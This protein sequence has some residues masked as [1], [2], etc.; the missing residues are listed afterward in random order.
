M[1]DNRHQ[2]P[3][4]EAFKRFAELAQEY[5]LFLS[6]LL[7]STNADLDHIGPIFSLKLGRTP[8]IGMTSFVICFCIPLTGNKF[9]TVLEWLGISWRK[10]EK[11][12]R[13]V[14]DPSWGES[15]PALTLEL[16]LSIWR[17]IDRRY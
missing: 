8:V 15:P 7:E 12:T 1:G 14:L 5:G 16:F 17:T 9:S 10:E 4:N 3:K 11:Y 13:V 6:R 2:I